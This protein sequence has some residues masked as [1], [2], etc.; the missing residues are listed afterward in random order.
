[1]PKAS[2][3]GLGRVEGEKSYCFFESYLSQILKH[4]LETHI[5]IIQCDLPFPR[6]II[7]S[8]VQSEF[9]VHEST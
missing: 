3:E 8:D 1:M 7:I 6:D 4:I 9:I 5:D 2:P